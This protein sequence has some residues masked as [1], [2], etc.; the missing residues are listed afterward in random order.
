MSMQI[1]EKAQDNYCVIKTVGSSKLQGDGY[2][3]KD[4]TF[5]PYF[6]PQDSKIVEY[7]T[8]VN[9]STS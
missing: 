2:K 7:H 9:G 8:P 4:G 6:F 1:I 3:R 5:Y